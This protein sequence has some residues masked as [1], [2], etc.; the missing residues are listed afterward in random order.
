MQ[1]NPPDEAET[2]VMSGRRT[3]SPEMKKFVDDA[4]QIKDSG[5]WAAMNDA[6]KA[7]AANPGADNAWQVQLLG[8]LCYQVFNEYLRL[9]EAAR[10][11]RPDTSLLAWRARNL[12]ELS[13]WATYFGRSRANALR[14]YEDA[15]R[16]VIDLLEKFEKAIKEAD[17]VAAIAEGKSDLLQRAT[18]EG[19][20][21]LD[22]KFMRVEAAASECGLKDMFGTMNKLLSKFTHPTAMQILGTADEAKRALQRDVFH[23]LGCLFFVGA[24]TAV[25]NSLSFV[26]PKSV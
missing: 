23:G 15:G 9:Q 24:F 19:L 8:G 3:M 21:S 14:L 25:E 18:N 4:A 1:Y 7:L 11:E 12:L 10:D 2:K 17:T 16:D 6:I 5:R 13:V 20:Q 22:G 26:R